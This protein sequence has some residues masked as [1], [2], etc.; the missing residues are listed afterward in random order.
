MSERCD[1]CGALYVLVG[2]VHR[3]VPRAP[4]PDVNRKGNRTALLSSEPKCTAHPDKLVKT[5]NPSKRSSSPPPKKK[6][7]KR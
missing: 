4:V 6:G 2:I 7:T 3:C 5:K 1:R